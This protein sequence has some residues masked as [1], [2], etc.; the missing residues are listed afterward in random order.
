MF[1]SQA[2]AP[3]HTFTNSLRRSRFKTLAIRRWN[4]TVG[5]ELAAWKYEDVWPRFGWLEPSRHTEM[6]AVSWAEGRCTITA[7]GTDCHSQR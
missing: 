4:G 2:C 7:T 6:N 1:R 3:Q 5:V